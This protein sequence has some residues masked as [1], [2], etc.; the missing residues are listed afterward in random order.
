M[1]RAPDGLTLTDLSDLGGV[2][3]R[4]VRYYVAQGLLRSPSGA[5]PGARYDGAHLARLRLI[6]R[7]QR[8]HLPLAEIRRR[9]GAL[10]DAEVIARAED[11]VAAPADSALDYV[12]QALEG[13]GVSGGAPLVRSSAPPLASSAPLPVPAA[14]FRPTAAA[15]TPAAYG[16]MEGIARSQW[17]RIVLDPDIELHVRRPLSR[18]Q[19]RAV[20]RLVAVARQIVR[21]DAP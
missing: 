20:D 5:G 1:E 19:A 21:E 17:D 2:T 13:R 15:E 10:S 4:T 11:V 16:P 18:A 3:P 14:T 8:E 6:R 12:R 9:L 7:L